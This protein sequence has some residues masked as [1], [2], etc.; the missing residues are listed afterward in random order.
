MNPDR[1]PEEATRQ[2][3]PAHTE[4]NPPVRPAQIAHDRLSRQRGDEPVTL[5]L[6]HQ[7]IEGL[8]GVRG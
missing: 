1:G 7:R 4:M 3:A 8:A 2:D 5:H 6:Y